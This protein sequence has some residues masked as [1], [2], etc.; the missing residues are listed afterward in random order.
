[1]IGVEFQA[2]SLVKK[3]EFDLFQHCSEL[4]APPEVKQPRVHGPFWGYVEKIFSLLLVGHYVL[5]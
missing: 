2:G 3:Q 5:L 1:M 4:Y